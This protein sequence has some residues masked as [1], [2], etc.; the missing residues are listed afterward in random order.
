MGGTCEFN[1]IVRPQNLTK[2]R[3]ISHDI[4]HFTQMAY[5]R[6]THVGCAFAR[7]TD[8]Y[9]TGLFACNYAS[10]NI[11]GYR[12]Y[13]CGIPASGCLFG[14]NSNY[15][16][17]CNVNEPID[18][19]QVYW[20]LIILSFSTRLALALGSG[21]AKRRLSTLLSLPAGNLTV[22]PFIRSIIHQSHFILHSLKNSH[23]IL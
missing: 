17:L 13:K 5:D 21:I 10:G 15:P 23:D 2:S 11:K 7:Y 8:N 12:V 9:K 18:P 3:S 20:A 1:S 14:K 4:G 22:T 19:N 6:A 16:A